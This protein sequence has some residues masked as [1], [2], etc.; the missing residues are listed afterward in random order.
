M[1]ISSIQYDYI[2]NTIRLHRTIITTASRRFEDS[3]ILETV[4]HLTLRTSA[5]YKYTFT[6]NPG[7]TYTINEGEGVSRMVSLSIGWQ[8]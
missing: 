5:R 1:I 4:I 8:V 2:I 3:F 6:I 7:T